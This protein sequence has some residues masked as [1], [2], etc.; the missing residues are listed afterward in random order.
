MFASQFRNISLSTPDDATRVHSTQ[1]LFVAGQCF[2]AYT[3]QAIVLD[4]LEGI[5]NDLGWATG[6]RVRDLREEWRRGERG[7]CGV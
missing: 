4:L 1:P 6:Y 5:E 2:S 3:E 7:G